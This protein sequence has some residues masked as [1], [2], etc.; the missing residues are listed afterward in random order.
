LPRSLVMKCSSRIAIA[1]VGALIFAG[2]REAKSKS[3]DPNAPT[4]IDGKV[5]QTVAR[6]DSAK[7]ARQ[8]KVGDQ[9]PDW[10]GLTGTDDKKHSLKDLEKDKAV[11]IVFTGNICPVAQAYEDRLNKLA[12][13]YKD[14]GVSIVAINVNPG[15]RDNLDAMK[16]RAEKK[17][18]VFAYLKD[19][20]QDSGRQYGATCT[21]HAFLLDGHRKIVYT[22]AIDDNMDEGAVKHHSLHDAIDAVLAGKEPSAGPKQFGCGIRYE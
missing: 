5:I 12:A 19:S 17:G 14:K 3:P 18:F 9:A 8:I 10:K 6:G 11:V 16:Q 2:C 15:D 20:S 1:I 13:D 4:K 22:G 7:E 21:P